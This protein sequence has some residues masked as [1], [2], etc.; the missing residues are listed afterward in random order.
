MTVNPSNTSLLPHSPGVYKYFNKS[1]I[2]IYIGKAKNLKKRVKSYFTG[3]RNHS[4]K[5]LKL[6]QEIDKIEVIITPTEF[7][8][9]L[10]ENNLIKVNQPKYNILLKDDKT[11]PYICVSK[12]RFPRIYSTRQLYH[13]K[14]EE[15]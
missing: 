8:A 2:L 15:I 10:L 14:L 5:T 4:R 7:D 12:D 6:V 1:G 13:A 3:K 9:L 11:F